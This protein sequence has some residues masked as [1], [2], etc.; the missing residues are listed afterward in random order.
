MKYLPLTFISSV[1]IFQK[2]PLDEISF[3]ISILSVSLK[4]IIQKAW[5]GFFSKIIEGKQYSCYC[6]K[7]TVLK[8]I[9]VQCVQA[10]RGKSHSRK[11][12]R[13]EQKQ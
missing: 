9:K 12:Y 1:L 8:L 5:K 7:S 13:L 10:N 11:D 4:E 6:R 2:S 3:G